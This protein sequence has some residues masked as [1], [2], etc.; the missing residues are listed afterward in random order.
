MLLLMGC[1]IP[2][3]VSTP[4]LL[5]VSASLDG[6]VGYLCR[7]QH[8]HSTTNRVVFSLMAGLAVGEYDH[9]NWDGYGF[10]WGWKQEVF[11][12]LSI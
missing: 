2:L 3:Q 11:S 10:L 6:G 12:F 5:L 1:G 8:P 7:S 9:N 4:P